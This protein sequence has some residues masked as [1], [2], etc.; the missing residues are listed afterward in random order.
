MPK[1]TFN[2]IPE[3][4]RER[5][6][7]E[8]AKLFAEKGF[9][10][11]DMNGLAR[12]AGVSKGS[13]YDYFDSKT[14][15]YLH[16]CRDGL[17]RS[18]N[19][20]YGG[21]DESWDLYTQV[22]RMFLNGVEFALKRPEYV[23]LYLNIASSGMERFAEELSKEV[24]QYTAEHLK[25]LIQA[26][27]DRGIVRS[28]IDVNLTA[29]LINSLYIMFVVSL[30]S[31]HFQIRIKEYLDMETDITAGSV[32]EHVERTVRLIENILRPVSKGDRNGKDDGWS[33]NSENVT[34]R[35]R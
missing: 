5:L 21:M 34:G 35:G 26:G 20:V 27:I 4:K 16:V 31:R 22:E 7:L 14:D 32:R 2:K 29:F 11:T 1:E 15:L 28:D 24:E 6:M 3:E 17:E 25:G 23:A 18:R 30:V 10:E 33:D 13:L 12:N 8:A 19:A 9:N